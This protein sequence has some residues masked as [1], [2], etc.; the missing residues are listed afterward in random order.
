V[1]RRVEILNRSKNEF[2]VKILALFMIFF[3][4]SLPNK[5][6]TNVLEKFNRKIT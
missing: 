3:G 5:F 1:G 4:D 2:T 6:W